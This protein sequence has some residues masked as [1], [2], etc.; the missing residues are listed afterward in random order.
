MQARAFSC[1][2]LLC[3]IRNVCVILFCFPRAQRVYENSYYWQYDMHCLVKRLKI[4]AVSLRFTICALTISWACTRFHGRVD[5]RN[6]SGCAIFRSFMLAIRTRRSRS[7]INLFQ[8]DSFGIAPLDMHLRRCDNDINLRLCI[9]F[10]NLLDNFL[11]NFLKTQVKEDAFD[12]F[13]NWIL[14]KDN[15]ELSK[16]YLKKRKRF[17]LRRY[18]KNIKNIVRS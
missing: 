6:E 7:A 13:S 17:D 16:N 9:G 3:R 8:I 11:M 15:F 14:S 2:V 18:W 5:A 1:N 4:G 10:L 12:H